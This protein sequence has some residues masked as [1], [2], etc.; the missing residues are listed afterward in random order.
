[1]DR[2]GM[3]KFDSLD[4]LSIHLAP[5]KAHQIPRQK[6]GNHDIDTKIMKDSNLSKLEDFS[7]T[8]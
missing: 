1:M 2:A 5:F 4:Y 8:F 7:M 3:L 6:L